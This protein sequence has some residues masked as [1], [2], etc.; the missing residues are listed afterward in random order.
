MSHR[1]SEVV[2]VRRLASSCYSQTLY[3]QDLCPICGGAFRI[4]LVSAG[5]CVL[6][7]AYLGAGKWLKVR[8][9]PTRSDVGERVVEAGFGVLRNGGSQCNAAGYRWK[10]FRG[11]RDHR[12]PFD[13]TW[14]KKFA[15]PGWR[16]FEFLEFC[17]AMDLEAVVT[18]NSKASSYAQITKIKM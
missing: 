1:Q 10:R 4:A 13:G 8:N 2:H 6:D 16:I 3:N 5:D 15:S 18:L 12:E 7:Q 14:Y 17:E 9:Q 11:D